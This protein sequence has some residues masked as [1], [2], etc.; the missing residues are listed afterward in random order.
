[1]KC[2]SGDVLRVEP[3]ESDSL[4]VVISSM[5]AQ[6]CVRKGCEAYLAFIL[7]TKE[8]DLKVESVSVVCE[9]P[10]VFLE[11]LPRLPPIREIEFGIELV[12]STAPI[13]ITPYRMALTE[14][15]ELKVQLQK[16]TDKG[17]VRLSYSS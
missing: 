15:K 4:L 12:P 7:N 16:L 13:S 3:D 8:S 1:M 14:L 17:F 11:E 10:N 9:Y 2:E 5:T 6:K